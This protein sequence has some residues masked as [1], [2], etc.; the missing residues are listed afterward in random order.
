[1]T[2]DTI[3]F[4]VYV[5]A[6]WIAYS[7]HGW[8]GAIVTFGAITVIMFITLVVN[9]YEDERAKRRHRER[10]EAAKKAL[11]AHVFGGGCNLCESPWNPEQDV[12]GLRSFDSIE[13]P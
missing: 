13:V 6:V 10:K 3:L 8:L 4:A 9:A 2:T 5:I 1:M 12:P 11:N 7:T